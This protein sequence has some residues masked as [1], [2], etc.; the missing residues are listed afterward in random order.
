[1]FL[2]FL[3]NRPRLNPNLWS[4][5][6]RTYCCLVFKLCAHYKVQCPGQGED[7]I[8]DNF[9]PTPPWHTQRGA[10]SSQPTPPVPVV[11]AGCSTREPVP[12]GPLTSHWVVSSLAEPFYSE[13]H[14]DLHPTHMQP[15]QSRPMDASAPRVLPGGRG[16]WQCIF[17]TE[18]HYCRHLSSPI[19]SVCHTE[20]NG[21][22][23][24]SL[25]PSYTPEAMKPTCEVQS[26]AE[27]GLAPADP[28]PCGPFP[29]CLGD[30]FTPY[31]W[32]LLPLPWG[33]SQ[34]TSSAP[35]P[36]AHRRLLQEGGEAIQGV[37][38]APRT[39]TIPPQQAPS[40]GKAPVGHE[41][42]APTSVTGRVTRQGHNLKELEADEA[43]G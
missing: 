3:P 37:P 23:W 32:H 17:I 14:A 34:A 24:C 27:G 31:S 9:T 39:P 25:P 36:C 43:T 19:S 4:S 40:A 41:E 16:S 22:C 12:A 28:T 20:E 5:L 26:P 1:M 18:T 8:R 6:W 10:H 15:S 7:S 2:L 29:S 35:V 33:T 42:W 13:T 38:A 21:C 11:P 30:P